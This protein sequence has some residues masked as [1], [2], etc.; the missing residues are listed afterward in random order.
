MA[1]LDAIKWKLKQY[2]LYLNYGFVKNPLTF[3]PMEILSSSRRRENSTHFM[4][5]YIHNYVETKF[6]LRFDAK[7]PFGT[8]KEV[9]ED[10][11]Y[12]EYPDF[13]PEQ[14]FDVIDVG[15]QCGDYAIMCSRYH[16]CNSV[17][18]I[19]PLKSNFTT[20]LKNIAL[21]EISNIS[22]V[23][24]AASNEDGEFSISYANDMA[25]QG[26]GKKSEVVRKLKLDHLGIK[27]VDLIKID[28]EGFEYDVL[29]GALETIKT[30]KPK[31]ILET[32]SLELKR[33][34]LQFL[35]EIGYE[36]IHEGR[37]VI[38]DTPGMDCIQ[39]LYLDTP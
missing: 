12:I 29:K 14:N 5:Y 1:L 20:L 10:G 4:E 32:H 24:A 21:N 3:F 11:I 22:A 2:G 31:I 27:K 9:F 18:A 37:M 23:H 26:T 16:G 15:T 35:N 39:N 8:L 33:L 38:A 36:V 13:V 28:V 34:C 25:F 7:T 17:T 30:N 6:G 19:E